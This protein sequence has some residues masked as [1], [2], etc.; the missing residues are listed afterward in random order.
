MPNKLLVLSDSHGFD[1]ELDLLWDRHSK[2]IEAIIHCGD[3]E[4]SPKADELEGMVTVKGNCDI[5]SFPEVVTHS[6]EGLRIYV[7]HGHLHG[8]KGSSDQIVQSA[9]RA[10]ADIVMHG[11]SHIAEAYENEGILVLNPGSVRLPR[12][13]VEATYALL[14]RKDNAVEISF[15]EFNTGKLVFKENWS[16]PSK[17]R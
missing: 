5:G 10:D 9:K 2:D 4:L 8:V 16:I 1:V 13:R 11:H 12:Q 14:E 7:S 15:L 17:K 3:S 6:W